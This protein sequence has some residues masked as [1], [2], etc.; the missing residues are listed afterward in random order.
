MNT[1]SRNPETLNT[2]SL[3]FIDSD[4]VMSE[5]PSVMNT[6]KMV[7]PDLERELSKDIGQISTVISTDSKLLRKIDLRVTVLLFAAYFLQFLDKVSEEM[8]K[9]PD[10]ML[11]RT[12]Y[13]QL[14]Q[15]HGSCTR[16]E[17]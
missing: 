7:D 12:G 8:F 9:P 14:F 4:S 6:N 1:L 15:C 17:A 16:F 13:P 10:H 3:S 2:S 11:T 5:K